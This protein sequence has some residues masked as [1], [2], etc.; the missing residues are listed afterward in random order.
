MVTIYGARGCVKRPAGASCGRLTPGLSLCQYEAGSGPLHARTETHDDERPDDGDGRADEVSR[1][2]TLGLHD[3]QPQEGRRD[4]N[5]AVRGVR[6]SCERRV[7]LGQGRGERN[8][9]GHSEER[10]ER[11]P[12]S[13]EPGPESEPTAGLKQRPPS[14]NRDVEHHGAI[15]RIMWPVVTNM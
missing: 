13:P 9:A 12:A 14:D 15:Y 5:S 3:P 2:G 1:V 4:I 7:G 8:Q 6:A 11:R 10:D